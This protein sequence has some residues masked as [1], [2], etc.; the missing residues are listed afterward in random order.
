MLKPGLWPP[1][2]PRTTESHA[3]L[4]V[5]EALAKQLPQ[6]WYAWH[7]LRIRVP[8]HPDAEADFVI[9]D[10]ARGILIVEVKGGRIEECDGLWFSNGKPL[11][12]PPR[13]QANGFR[14]E[15]LQL[16]HSKQIDPPSCG[17]ATC[18]PDTE[19]DCGPTQGDLVGCVLG[20]QDLRWLGEALPKV[21]DCALPSGYRPKGKWLQ[22]IH[23]LWGN[24]WVPKMDFGLQARLEKEARIRL[25]TEQF[26]MLQGAMENDSVLVTGA[27]GTGKTVVAL[28]LARK[29][30]EIGKRVLVLCFT[31]PRA[32]AGPA[33][34]C[35]ESGSLGYQA[36][37]RRPAYAGRQA[38][39]NRRHAGIL[40]WCRSGGG[41]RGSAEAQSGLGC[42]HCG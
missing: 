12:K 6:G 9:A 18:F 41:C 11:K 24:L 10:P 8:G 36:L 28:A 37:C 30:A 34:R 5:Y 13:E 21:M 23:D 16:L 15:L 35:T 25:D 39:R 26:E 3:E 14:H 17:V 29:L 27:A 31:E 1:H 2:K 19:F 22:A 38:R 4:A 33:D 42:G 20:A 7:S 40:V 32:L